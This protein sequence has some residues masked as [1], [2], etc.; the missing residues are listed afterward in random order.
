MKTA[1]A[2]LALLVFCG[3]GPAQTKDDDQLAPNIRLYHPKNM[4]FQ[5]AYQVAEF[6]NSVLGP[7]TKVYWDDVPHSLVIRTD[8][9]PRPT[10]MDAAEALLKRFDVAEPVKTPAAIAAAMGLDCTVYLIRASIGTPALAL[11]QPPLIPPPAIH[12]RGAPAVPVPGE[13][14]PAIDEMKHSFGYDSY[15]LWDTQVLHS[16]SGADL[17]GILPVEATAASSPYVYSMS[18]GGTYLT[19][20]GKNLTI[21]KFEFSVRMPSA[22]YKDGIESHIKTEVTIHEGQKLVLGKIRLMP[23]EHADLFLVLATKPH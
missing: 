5:R 14:Q 8:L 15:S 11:P 17:Q 21:H 12:V 9:P 6:V 20:D 13:L 16:T 1:I 4:S 23:Q 2:I 10:D 19:P 22:I 3:P 7:R 18:Y